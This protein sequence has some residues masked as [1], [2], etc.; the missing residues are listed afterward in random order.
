[1]YVLHAQTAHS[2]VCPLTPFVGLGFRLGVIPH[3]W[4]LMTLG[5]WISK[6]CGHSPFEVQG[7]LLLL[8]GLLGRHGIE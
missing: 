5:S 6:I 1:M 8:L 7:E 3:A 2:A 4:P